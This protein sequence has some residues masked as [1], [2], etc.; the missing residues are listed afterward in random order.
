MIPFNLSL[1]SFAMNRKSAAIQP[2]FKKCPNC[3][4]E[5]RDRKNLLSDPDAEI[6]GYQV[7]FLKLKAGYF[8]FNHSCKGTFSVQ[9]GRFSNLYDGPIFTKRETGSDECPEY[10][11]HRDELRPCPVHCECAYVREI[12]QIIKNWLKGSDS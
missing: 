3:G 9:A 1:E 2:A 12:L 4:Y 11:L 6:I 10:C 8:M 5:W 7:N